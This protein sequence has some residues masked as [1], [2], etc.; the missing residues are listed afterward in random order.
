MTAFV[1]G[2][3]FIHW[4]Q[5]VERSP[6]LQCWGGGFTMNTSILSELWISTSSEV[7]TLRRIQTYSLCTAFIVILLKT[8]ERSQLKS[9]KF[10][11]PFGASS[12]ADSNRPPSS[13]KKISTLIQPLFTKL[14]QHLDWVSKVNWGPA[15]R[16]WKLY[17]FTP[18]GS[19]IINKLFTPG[20]WHHNPGIYSWLKESEGQQ[21]GTSPT[22]PTKWFTYDVPC[23]T[24]Y[25]FKVI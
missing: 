6:R 22:T 23:E 14:I 7:L 20:G 13:P 12:H 15:W 18:G 5:R 25:Y 24:I 4:A 10:T 21:T 8:G 2:F 9:T 17:V 16:D 3:L 1:H 19:H 11:I